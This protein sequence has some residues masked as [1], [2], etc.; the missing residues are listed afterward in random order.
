MEL[1]H[2]ATFLAV[3][4]AGNLTAAARDLHLSQP[5]VSAHIKALEAE[6][7]SP[8]FVRMARGVTATPIAHQLADDIATPLDALHHVAHTLNPS[9]PAATASCFLGG[10]SDALSAL[11]LPALAPLIA[12]G[13]RLR[14][15][16]GLT[17][18]LLEA[19]SDGELDLVIATTPRRRRNVVTEPLFVERLQ[20]LGAAALV[21]GLDARR[22]RSNPV[23]VLRELPLLSYDVNVPL[24]RRYFR[25][26]F[27]LEQPPPPQVTMSDLRALDFLART[28]AGWTVLPDYLA[29]AP[30]ACGELVLLHQPSS[31]P[32]NTVHLAT[33]ASRRHHPA[34]AAVHEHLTAHF[35]GRRSEYGNPVVPVGCI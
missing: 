5:A 15:R 19:L 30:L 28:G 1:S 18:P 26:E 9:A 7:A 12:D 25:Q 31:P 22:L 27:P 17:R 29:A 8:L 20:L 21:E 2:L 4:R 24:V 6:V 23:A 32:I 3:Y 14:V 10:P 33:R 13:L 34:I 16:T 11:I 35:L